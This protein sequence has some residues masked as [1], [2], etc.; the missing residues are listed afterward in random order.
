[1]KASKSELKGFRRLT[2]GLALA[3]LLPAAGAR[4]QETN[5]TTGEALPGVPA[6]ATEGAKF[7]L[8]YGVGLTTNYISKGLTQTDNQPAM[9]PYVELGYGIGYVGLWASNASFGGVYDNE[10]DVSIGIRPGFGKWSFDLGFVQYFYQKDD[11][12]YG[13]A[14][15][16]GKYALNDQVTLKAQYY[17]EVYANKDWLYVG[18]SYSD[19][20]W[21]LT[22]SGGVGSDFG[23]NDFSED[24]VAADIGVTKDLGDHAS[25]DI[26]ASYSSIEGNRLIASLA[27]F[28]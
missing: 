17:H 19:L 26:R 22:V 1:M 25:I 24:S 10:L 6:P 12:D 8:S 15:L 16:F 28:N 13:E 5:P 21:D 4:A 3:M 7:Q 23:T 11:A 27:F 2:H 14:Y 9:Q 20:P 18:G